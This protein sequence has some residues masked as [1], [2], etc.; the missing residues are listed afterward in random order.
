MFSIIMVLVGCG[1]TLDG[2]AGTAGKLSGDTGEEIT[3]TADTADTADTGETGDT[4]APDSGLDSG[5]DRGAVI[6]EI[7]CKSTGESYDVSF[8]APV[9]PGDEVVL[10]GH[11]S[12]GYK[13]YR[14]AQGP[15]T[16]L[17]SDWDAVN[18]EFDKEGHVVVLCNWWDDSQYLFFVMDDFVLTVNPS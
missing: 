14:A 17:P 12:D 13:A 10:F 5:Y 8:A 18:V 3:D 6:E 15:D 4:A 16:A 7:K 2:N 1:S 11:W 9:E